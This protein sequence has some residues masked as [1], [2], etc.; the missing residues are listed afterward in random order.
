[1]YRIDEETLTDVQE[2]RDKYP[3]IVRELGKKYLTAVRNAR[4]I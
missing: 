4:K 2:Y 3:E 1:L